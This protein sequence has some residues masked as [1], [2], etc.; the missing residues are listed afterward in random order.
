MR[1]VLNLGLGLYNDQFTKLTLAKL[2]ATLIVNKQKCKICIDDLIIK[3][4]TYAAKS[5][6]CVCKSL[7]IL[8]NSMYKLSNTRGRDDRIFNK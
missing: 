1:N 3:R 7:N 5:Y 4:D 6:A 2:G 8:R